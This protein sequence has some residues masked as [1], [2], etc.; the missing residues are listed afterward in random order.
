MNIKSWLKNKKIGVLYGGL[1]AERDISILTGKAVLKA[2][3]EE[4][5]N[6][7][8]IDAGRD[9][10]SQIKR[11]R[12]DFAF[13]ALHGPWGEDGTIQ[14]MLEIMGI[15]YSG[16][17]VLAS[18]LALNK[19]YSKRI[20]DSLGIPTPKWWVFNKKNF[21]ARFLTSR[22]PLVIKPAAQGSAIGVSLVKDKKGL[23][24]AARRAFRLNS[25]IIAEKY[26]GGTE[27]TVGIL[28]GRALP[29]IE[30]VPEGS[31]Y[32]FKSKYKPGQSKHI[33][34]PRLP[35]SVIKNAQQLGLRAFNA[36]GCKA[37]SRVDIIVD[38]RNKPW[39]LEVNTVPGMTETSLLPDAARACGIGFSKL[40]LKII[41][42]SLNTERYG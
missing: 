12:I 11:S 5:C 25:E 13:I 16:C 17:G 32:D 41:E 39:V 1:S 8:G 9:S 4:K 40:V 34:P 10:A 3:K 23:N 6:V 20:F 21:N 42:Y 22:F 2:L 15:P 26:I 29:V 31:F 30:I 37:V 36:L 18:S 28:G 35:K 19:I 38:K 7:V 24:N 27:I 14:G 33:I